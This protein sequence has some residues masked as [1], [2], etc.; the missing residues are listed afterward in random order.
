MTTATKRISKPNRGWPALVAVGGS[1][2]S[3]PA[4]ALETGDVTVHSRLGEPLRASIAYS[5]APNESIAGNCVTVTRGPSP[6]GLPSIGTASVS[7]ANGIIS[8]VGSQPLREPMMSARV[9]INCPYTPNLSREYMLFID[10]PAYVAPPST[11]VTATVATGAVRN[12]PRAEPRVARETRSEPARAAE[13]RRATAVKDIAQGA[14]YRVQAGD[15]LSEIASRIENRSLK[16]WPAVNALFDANPNA[17][18]DN[19]PNKLKAG[20]T[21]VIPASI[22]GNASV[23][24]A[25]VTQAAPVAADTTPASSSTVAEPAVTATANAIPIPAEIE[26]GAD[27][28]AGSNAAAPIENTSDLQP[29]EAVDST[30]VVSDNPFVEPAETVIIPDTSLEGPTTQSSSPNVPTAVVVPKA[31]APAGGTNWLYWLGGAGLLVILALLL[32]GRRFRGETTSPGIAYDAAPMRRKSDTEKMESLIVEESPYQLDDNSPTEENLTLDADLVTGSGLADGTSMDVNEE[33]GFAAA[34]PVDLELP[35][36]PDAPADDTADMLPAA[37]VEEETILESEVLPD[38]DDYDIS[39]IVDAT[40]MPQP[41]DV[42]KRDLQAVE[43]STSDDDTD[44]TDN[45]TIAEEAGL[46]LLARDYEDEFTATQALN[47]EIQRAAQDLKLAVDGSD[48]GETAETAVM[49]MASVTELDITSEMPSAANADEVIAL[50][51]TVEMP[52]KN[53]SDEEVD[54]VTMQ[55]ESKKGA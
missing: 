11:S 36:E 2:A 19:D 25:T 35:F 49:P 42:T 38:D 3:L 9:V 51:P 32:F 30:G 22:G 43:V 18:I 10:P 23:A 39:M 27:S 52:I 12:E 40:K 28:V 21:L 46:D 8:L 50:D 44:A 13:P 15:T 29:A 47:K 45:Y 26:V 20:A 4:A 1:I 53:D 37:M 31:D 54:T 24:N 34:T 48:P 14:E 7:V 41:D 5:L 17:F 55:L 16:L 6:S 33:F